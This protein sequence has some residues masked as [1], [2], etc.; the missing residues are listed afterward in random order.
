MGIQRYQDGV[1]GDARRGRDDGGWK[2]EGRDVGARAL[3]E[4]GGPGGSCGRGEVEVLRRSTRSAT[5]VAPVVEGRS[6]GLGA[7][8]LPGV[9]TLGIV[10]YVV[11]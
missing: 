9:D 8:R 5:L 3:D 6:L 2:D 11:L 1:W 10:L 7:R 4:L